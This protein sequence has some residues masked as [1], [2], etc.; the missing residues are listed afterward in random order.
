MRR[1]PKKTSVSMNTRV[2]HTNTL[3]RTDTG[4][5]RNFGPS[6]DGLVRCELELTTRELDLLELAIQI[7]SEQPRVFGADDAINSSMTRVVVSLA[8]GILAKVR[9]MRL[10]HATA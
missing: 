5:E 2:F 8:D 6:R 4:H 3:R 9:R 7:V 10:S 1:A